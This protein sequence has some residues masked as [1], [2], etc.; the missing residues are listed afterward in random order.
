MKDNK[1]TSV[2]LLYGQHFAQ[3]V[4]GNVFIG[5]QLPAG[6]A[7]ALWSAT[8]QQCGVMNPAGSGKFLV[9][10]RVTGTYVSGTGIVDGLCL[11]FVPGCGAGVTAGGV[12]A[13]T[14]IASVPSLL[15]GSAGKMVFM[16]AGITCTAP[17]RLVSLGQNT[18][19]GATVAA[20]TNTPLIYDFDG[21][22][23]VPPT[24]ALI[25]AADIT[26]ITAVYSFS[27]IWAEVLVDVVNVG[28]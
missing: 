3:A 24:Y 13:A 17:T 27:I 26:G 4:N 9:P 19:V 2:S 21:M 1:G 16:S 12:T 5:N 8:T 18:E 10:L 20:V 15:G 28:W 11:A 23:I 6:V 22:I 14:T 7:P 25:I